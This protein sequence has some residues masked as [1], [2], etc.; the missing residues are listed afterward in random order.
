MTKRILVVDDEPNIRLSFR[1][2]LLSD[3]WQVEEAANGMEAVEKARK[4]PYDVMLIDLRMPG[5]DGL[6]TLAKLQE[7]GLRIPAVMVSAHATTDTVLQAVRL[8][9]LDCPH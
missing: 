8:G 6:Q 2:G 5:M 1:Y 7:A 3:A 4:A 9:T